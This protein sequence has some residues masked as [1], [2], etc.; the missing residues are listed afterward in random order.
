MAETINGQ[1]LNYFQR[2]S[3]NSSAA[4]GNR[5]GGFAFHPCFIPPSLRYVAASRG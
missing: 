4:A 2:L 3:V 5:S 1:A